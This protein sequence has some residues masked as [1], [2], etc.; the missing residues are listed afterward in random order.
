MYWPGLDDEMLT[1]PP[2]SI[3]CVDEEDDG[4]DNIATRQLEII[5][6]TQVRMQYKQYNMRNIVCSI[7]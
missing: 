1:F 4:D 5:S 2:L 3:R 6:K 7:R